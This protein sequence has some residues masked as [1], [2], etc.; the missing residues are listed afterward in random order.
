MFFASCKKD[1]ENDLGDLEDA[2][3][4]LPAAFGDTQ[5]N[6][7]GKKF[8]VLTHE[9][10]TSN[11]AF[12]IV[13][14]VVNEEL[15]D[16]AIN[17]AVEER[18]TKI[19]KYFG[20]VI[21]R[22]KDAS[23]LG[24]HTVASN[25]C[26]QNDT[27]YSA[28]R[29][30]VNQALSIALTG[31]LVDLN[32]QNYIDL[33]ESYWDQ[34]IINSMLLYGGAY[35]G[36]GDICTV[37]DDASWCVL[38]NKKVYEDK[39]GRQASELYDLVKQGGWTL[40]VLGGY[41]KDYEKHDENANIWATN[42]SGE[43]RYGLMTQFSVVPALMVSSG[44]TLTVL[45]PGDHYG[46]DVRTQGELDSTVEKLWA[47]MGQDVSNKDWLL[48]T[49]DVDDSGEYTNGRDTFADIYRP[50]FMKDRALFFICHVG[51]ISLMRDMES[52]FGIL[53]MPKLESTQ[54][55]YGNTIM[56]DCA[57]CYVIPDVFKK[58]KD[59]EF[60]AYML[61]ALAF[62]S[63]NEYDQMNGT[64]SSLTF[65]YY[66]TVLQRKATRDEESME[67]LDILFDNRTFDIAMALNLSDFNGVISEV[68]KN[69]TTNVF[70]SEYASKV[71]QNGIYNDLVSEL[72]T[73]SGA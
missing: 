39:P 24:A 59:V 67:M 4:D 69:D 40:D 15:G 22:K 51:T 9:D 33:E 49:N 25:V 42:Y 70:A 17:K 66:N 61:E 1:D 71:G 54:A 13:D 14:L 36:L 26:N 38:F 52:E 16:E 28:F 50:L 10:R 23:Y 72:K 2:E 8:T 46:I 30:R 60:S 41:A 12:N 29:L 20:V 64:E 32:Q 21:E 27:S 48:R 34:A 56:Y 55:N 53:P 73:L 6:Y 5:K 7:S 65:A 62:Y 43:G 45:N 68:M 11:Q 3:G 18:N 57:D 44:K 19:R 31:K 37:D 35:F 58:A 63:S 47:F